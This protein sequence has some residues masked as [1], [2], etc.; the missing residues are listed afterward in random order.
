[1]LF[2]LN[3]GLFEWDTEKERLNFEKH[4]VHFE[5]A[6][7]VFRDEN[8]IELYDEEHSDDEDRYN[9]IGKVEDVLFVVFTERRERIRLISARIATPAE[10][11]M[12]HDSIL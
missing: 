1:M 8:R 2:E 10:R 9:T 12:Y 3:D 7:R 11:R 4:R 5:T 6:A